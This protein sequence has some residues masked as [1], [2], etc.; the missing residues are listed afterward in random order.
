MTTYTELKQQILDYC[1]TYSAVL[2]DVII[3]DII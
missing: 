2:T 3:N 1:E